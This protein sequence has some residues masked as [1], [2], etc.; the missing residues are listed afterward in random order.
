MSEKVHIEKLVHG[1]QGI[2]K[3]EDGR[4]VFVWNALPG[5][6][7][8][9]RITKNKKDY[10]EA[11]AEEILD[12]SKSRIEPKDEA[13]LSTSPW[14]ILDL[15][16]E[17]KSKK[18]ILI[19]AFQREGVDLPKDIKFYNSEQQWHYRNKMEY[20]FW[21]DDEG[22]HLALFHRGSHGKRI[23]EGSSLARPEIDDV[24]TKLIS[25][26]NKNNIRGS[27]LKTA[28]LRCDQKGNVVVALFVKNEQFP[29]IKELEGLCQGIT[30][31]YSNPKS[32]ASV[33]TKELYRF[34][35]VILTDK[36]TDIDIS[37]NVHS[38]FQ[39]NLPVFEFVAKRIRELTQASREIV[40]MYS[41]VGTL[42][43]ISNAST[44]VDVDSENI[45]MARLNVGTKTIEIV[46]ASTEKAL[47]YITS[48]STLI[49]DPPRSGLHKKVVEKI[50]ES[51]PCNIIYLS[52]NPAT[53]ARDIALLCENYK[54][55][56]L[57]GYNFFPRTPHIESL[58]VMMV[59]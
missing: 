18:E 32:P 12:P 42:G 31:C 43:L 10:A 28:V 6:L 57:E 44:L 53:Q 3:L 20:S 33:I 40:D 19:E 7:V 17:N 13:Y 50:L 34:G 47:E 8:N 51:K 45:V 38:F 54:L 9:A 11:I 14:Q 35:D 41:G 49:V 29:K 30:V 24:A 46:E 2:G 48:G 16:T 23:V 58:A 5:E 37:Y 56:S 22:L 27:Q 39:V 55:K 36:V 1:G 25:I 26:L 15:E 59:A 4:K 21:A 52:C